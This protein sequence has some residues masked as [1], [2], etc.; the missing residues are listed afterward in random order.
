MQTER[1]ENQSSRSH[2]SG[3]CDTKTQLLSFFLTASQDAHLDCSQLIVLLYTYLHKAEAH[4]DQ[5]TN[6]PFFLQWSLSSVSS[7]FWIKCLTGVSVKET[8]YK[9][10]DGMGQID[11]NF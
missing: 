5:V 8:S 4:M 7:E 2:K 6:F 11:S 9:N 10:E 1:T 3:P